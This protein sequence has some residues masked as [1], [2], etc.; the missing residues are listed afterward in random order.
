MK[1]YALSRSR[2]AHTW[3][4]FLAAEYAPILQTHFLKGRDIECQQ[5]V[6]PQK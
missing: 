4:P 5:D 3:R 6:S 2:L 1:G